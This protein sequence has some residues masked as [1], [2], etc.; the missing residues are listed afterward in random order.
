MHDRPDE[1][2]WE[3]RELYKP[4]VGYCVCPAYDCEITL[5]PV[6]EW[7]RFPVTCHTAPNDISDVLALLYSR[8]SYSWHHH[9][10]FRFDARPVQGFDITRRRKLRAV[11]SRQSQTHSTRTERQNLQHGTVERGQSFFRAAAQTQIPADDLPRAAVDHRNQ[12]RPPYRWTRPDLGH[13]RLPD[14][15]RM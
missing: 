12:I 6:P 11:V 3:A 14:V 5:I 13:V 8:L 4:Q 1:P 2:C 7:F 15:I 10:S 9:R